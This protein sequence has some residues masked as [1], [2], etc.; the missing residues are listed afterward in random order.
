M[1][2]YSTSSDND[3]NT[4]ITPSRPIPPEILHQ[5]FSLLP[6]RVIRCCALVSRSWNSSAIPYLY[7]NIVLRTHT[8][9]A[10]L[11]RTFASPNAPHLGEQV[12][13]L[14]LLVSPPLLPD[15]KSHAW[16]R[17]REIPPFSPHADE[18]YP[19]INTGCKE[20]EWLETHVTDADLRS[21]LI[22]CP[23][24]GAIHLNGCS[25]LT[26]TTLVTLADSCRQGVLHTIH[27]A[28]L[29]TVT[30]PSI[31]HLVQRHGPHLRNVDLSLCTSLTPASVA[32]LARATGPRL[33]H[34]RLNS[35]ASLTD[36]SIGAV[37]EWC[38]NIRLLHLVRCWKVTDGPMTAIA[39]RCRRLRYLSVAFATNVTE[40]GLTALV[41]QCAELAWL[42]ITA[43]GVRL[44][45][46]EAVLRRWTQ[47]R[48]Q[49]GRGEM[50]VVDRKVLLV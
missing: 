23:N 18:N 4:S 9:L 20:T 29:R 43:C 12:R 14:A 11:N 46:K 49:T 42:D 31:V 30:D 41:N 22:R 17:D 24:L 44:F 13:S 7:Q 38:P 47:V 32:L 35:I 1:N 40:E 26:D 6:I 3:R 27:I 21:I 19:E 5:I 36:D 10:F 45:F 16:D 48:T 25:Q 15:W 33:T 37:A 8:Q 34:L 2:V 39:Q 50:A 28:L